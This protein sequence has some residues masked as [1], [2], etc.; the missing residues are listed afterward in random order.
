MRLCGRVLVVV[1]VFHSC[2]ATGAIRSSRF[3]LDET[4]ESVE[5]LLLFLHSKI[6]QMSLDS[7]FG[8]AI[9]SGQI[10]SALRCI[11]GTDSVYAVGLIRKLNH[12]KNLSSILLSNSRKEL[13]QK[14]EVAFNA[15][16]GLLDPAY[17]ETHSPQ[18]TCRGSHGGP[19]LPQRVALA[20]EQ[21]PDGAESDAC[22]ARLLSRPC[23][24]SEPLC[25]R[26]VEFAPEASAAEGYAL[27]HRLIYALVASKAPHCMGKRKSDF[28]AITRSICCKML[29]EA[30]DIADN[31]FPW[32]YQDLFME[33]VA[34][35]GVVN[36][37]E[38]AEPAW[39]RSVLSWQRPSGCY[40]NSK[41]IASAQVSRSI[42]K[43]SESVMDYGCLSHASGVALA[44]LATNIRF[45][46]NQIFC[47]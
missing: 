45:I 5:R 29:Q 22:L 40:G 23:D 33:Q 2:L 43:R 44:S 10:S 25:W 28:G 39:L 17:W 21:R 32:Q 11:K 1:I 26:R 31:D 46:V 13:R 41:E 3:L 4:L 19:G 27:S 14:I 47:Q 34:L 24:G 42:A 30:K 36:F 15:L 6:D 37:S 18:L 7:A 8:V 35:C 38:F 20:M 12:V 9:A 16:G